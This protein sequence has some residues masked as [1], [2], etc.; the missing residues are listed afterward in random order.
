MK[1]IKEK[2][3]ALIAMLFSLVSW[4]FYLSAHLV[5]TY[6]TRTEEN[7]LLPFTLYL[8]SMFFS[9]V[10]SI[11][12][13]A[14]LILCI[15]RFKKISKPFWHA[16]LTLLVAGLFPMHTFI[17]DRQYPIWTA[18]FALVF[19][20]ELVSIVFC[21]KKKT[22]LYDD[23]SNMQ[24]LSDQ[25]NIVVSVHEDAEQAQ[26]I[27]S[28]TTELGNVRRITFMKRII[29]KIPAI[30]A[31][32]LGLVCFGYL[33][34][35]EVVA[36]NPALGPQPSS[37]AITPEHACFMTGYI[38]SFVSVLPFMVEGICSIVRAARGTCKKDNLLNVISAVLTFCMIPMVGMAPPTM[39]FCYYGVACA[40]E[41]VFII[42]HC[43]KKPSKYLY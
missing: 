21:L 25:N 15:M 22:P 20:A 17:N 3:P 19:V 4:G 6:G 5:S 41:L 7:E 38:L 31:I 13:L 33:I 30:I 37:P 23:E 1:R 39:W 36:K 12:Y 40:A 34:A 28:P 8:V 18:Y 9:L 10:A 14:E 27:A 24:T 32:I 11:P 29:G 35:S 26:H 2:I 43:V 42:L 16:A